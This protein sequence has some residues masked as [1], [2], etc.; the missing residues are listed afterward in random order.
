M[1]AE[2]K[3][4]L[5]PVTDM[6]KFLSKWQKSDRQ[7]VRNRI[8][9]VVKPEDLSKSD[10]QRSSSLVQAYS[11]RLGQI[12]KKL[13]EKDTL[14][15]N[16]VVRAI[17]AHEAHRAKMLANEL[18]EIR[19]MNKMVSQARLAFEQISLRLETVRDLGDL[20]VTLSPAVSAIKGVQLNLSTV[21]PE[22]E[23]EIGEIS[24]LLSTL[25]SESGQLGSPNQIGFE[26][27]SSDAE[28]ILAEAS[29]ALMQTMKEKFPD[30]PETDT[31]AEYETA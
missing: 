29:F 14:M 31:A 10:L 20:A 24:D 17:Q 30:V 15:L 13:A 16:S 7:G 19:K 26:P 22:A 6:A 23:G 18:S 25:M 11:Q 4:L 8:K 9:R 1:T 3:G 2:S 12:S 27:T 5:D 28:N 21:I